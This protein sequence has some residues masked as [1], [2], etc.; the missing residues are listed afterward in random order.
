MIQNSVQESGQL[1]RLI[2]DITLAASENVHLHNR[3]TDIHTVAVV[4]HCCG[5]GQ[6]DDVVFYRDHVYLMCT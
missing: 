5:T 4:K 6:R 1:L 2:A 3:V